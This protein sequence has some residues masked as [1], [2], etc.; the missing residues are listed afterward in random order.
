MLRKKVMIRLD[1]NINAVYVMCIMDIATLKCHDKHVQQKQHQQ[2]PAPQ[3][4]WSS[5]ALTLQPW[6]ALLLL[7]NTTVID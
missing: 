5:S 4:A 3:Q 6:L 1:K 2:H 7:L